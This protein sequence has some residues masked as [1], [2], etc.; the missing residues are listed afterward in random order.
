MEYPTPGNLSVLSADIHTYRPGTWAGENNP[1]GTVRG[2]WTEQIGEITGASAAEWRR[3]EALRQKYADELAIDAMIRMDRAR[4]V[5]FGWRTADRRAYDATLQAMAP[6]EFADYKRWESIWQEVTGE[7]LPEVTFGDAKQVV[8]GRDRVSLAYAPGEVGQQPLVMG[9]NF[10]LPP[11]S[12]Y[13]GMRYHGYLK[14]DDGDLP[15]VSFLY[16]KRQKDGTFETEERVVAVTGFAW[17]K[18]RDHMHQPE[19]MFVV[20]IDIGRYAPLAD[21]QP[22]RLELAESEFTSWG[23][24]KPM[25]AKYFSVDCIDKRP[26]LPGAPVPV[27]ANP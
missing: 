25:S 10:D 17:G 9:D 7:H 22:S 3:S 24:V 12:P 21:G 11:N 5:L 20:G 1:L 13:R 18:H 14:T 2:D 6:E 19:G 23:D 15:I 8:Y 16:Y 27:V 4:R 26:T